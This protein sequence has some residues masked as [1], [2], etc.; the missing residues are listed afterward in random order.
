VSKQAG[1]IVLVPGTVGS[2]H[3]PVWLNSAELTIRLLSPLVLVIWHVNLV[4]WHLLEEKILFYMTKACHSSQLPKFLDSDF[5]IEFLD[6]TK[7]LL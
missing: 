4:V 5:K 7:Q 1:A 2:H 3:Q 6:P